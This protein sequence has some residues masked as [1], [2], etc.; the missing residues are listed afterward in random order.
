MVMFCAAA[1]IGEAQE[2]K[3]ATAA[4]EAYRRIYEQNDSAALAVYAEEGVI[5]FFDEKSGKSKA[6]PMGM[7][8]TLILS[9]IPG[10]AAK[11]E[12]VVF[13]Q[14]PEVA[15]T[16]DIHS[17]R[18]ERTTYPEGATLQYIVDIRKSR[19]SSFQV[20]REIL[21]TPR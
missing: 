1:A 17:W 20:A 19:S 13:S 11:G 4:Y 18:G 14:Q 12:H 16:G 7:Y 10:A 3:S 6:I 2:F 5:R 15:Q 21:L 9:M 8:K